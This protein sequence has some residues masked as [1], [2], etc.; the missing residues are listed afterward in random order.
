LLETPGHDPRVSSLDKVSAALEL[1]IGGI[2]ALLGGFLLED[3]RSFRSAS[4]RY[5]HVVDQIDDVALLSAAV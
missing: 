3:G 4:I 1:P 2:T 5:Q